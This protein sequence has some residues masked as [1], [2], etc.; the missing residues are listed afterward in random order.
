MTQRTVKSIVPQ[1]GCRPRRHGITLTDAERTD[2]ELAMPKP[3]RYQ[4]VEVSGTPLE[5]GRQLGEAAREAIRGFA[6]VA[7]DRMNLTV[8]ISRAKALEVAAASFPFVEKYSPEHLEEMRGMAESS[9]VSIKELMLLQ[10]RNQLQPERDAGCTSFAAATPEKA[11]DSVVG[12]NWDN[13]PVLDEFTIVLTRRPTGKPAFL[14]ATQVGLIGYIGVNDRG[15]GLCLNTLP[16]P[17]RDFGVPHYFMVRNMYE[18]DSLDGVVEAVRRAE[19]AI[20]ANVMLMTPQG[21]A[22]L[23]ITVDE[24]RVLQ[25]PESRLV[26]HTNHCVHPDFVSIND[27]FSELIESH[28]RKHRVD[29]LFAE[30]NNATEIDRLKRILSDHDNHPKSICRHENDH[31]KN[32]FWTTV[33]S[34]IIEADHGRMHLTRGNPCEQPYETYQLT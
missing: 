25:D 5:M 34:V 15:I 28:P 17:N 21:P 18:V 7:L 4:E 31:P 14:N 12:Q 27:E 30:S 20:P 11:T 24:V 19:R 6:E 10:I 13:D 8:P 1:I 9:G 33:F 26:T 3:T 29:A 16:A 22:D 2:G 23:E 32:G